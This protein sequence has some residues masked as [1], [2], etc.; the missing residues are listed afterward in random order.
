MLTVFKRIFKVG[1]QN[2]WRNGWLST[3]TVSV[4]V[5]A[6]SIILGVLLALVLSQALILNLQDKID[7]SVYFNSGTP[8]E[9]ILDLKNDL[10]NQKEVKN[11]EYVSEANAL[12]KFKEKYQSNS[13]VIQSLS[14]LDENPLEAS[15]DIKANDPEK[16]A[17]IVGFLENKKY[18]A[19]ISKINYYE[20]KEII[21]RLSGLTSAVRKVGF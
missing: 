13:V 4:M 7:V 12:E 17:S 19:I 8:E 2:F 10:S 21:D 1:F 18:E 6:L 14:E 9:S 5:M 11:I 3:A 15:L 20:N 16:F